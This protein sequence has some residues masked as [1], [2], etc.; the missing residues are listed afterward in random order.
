M[1]S[2][3]KSHQLI[4]YYSTTHPRDAEI[5]METLIDAW[6]YYLETNDIKIFSNFWESLEWVIPH[7]IRQEFA[8]DRKYWNSLTFIIKLS[9]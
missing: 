3:L 4:T 5:L 2:F 1:E 6:N 9:L 8:A 7:R